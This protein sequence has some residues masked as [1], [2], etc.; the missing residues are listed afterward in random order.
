MDIEFKISIIEK[1]KR[2]ITLRKFCRIQDRFMQ[3]EGE[4]KVI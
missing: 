2:S 4:T 1:A 3:M